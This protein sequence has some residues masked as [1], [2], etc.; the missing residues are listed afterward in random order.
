MFVMTRLR[1]PEGDPVAADEIRA[2]LQASLEIL[3]EK[4]GFVGGEVGRNMDDPGL[5]VLATRWE[6]VGSYR[7]ALGS[8]ESKMFI[9]PLMVHAIDEPS[10]YEPAEPGETLNRSIPRS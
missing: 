1:A 8:Y 4:P 10:A 2:G 3:A 7:R 5:W 9:H 6:N